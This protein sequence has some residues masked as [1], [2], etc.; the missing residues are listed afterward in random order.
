MWA[1]PGT[2]PCHACARDGLSPWKSEPANVRPPDASIAIVGVGNRAAGDDAAGLLVIDAL[3]GR[4]MHPATV[5]IEAGLAGP[6]LV[7]QMEG[8]AKIVLVDAVDMG[9]EPGAVKCFTPQEV[10]STKPRDRMS[11]HG[12]DLLEVIGLA[13]RLDVCPDDVVIVGIQPASGAYGGEV[14]AGVREA[15]G[16]A[17]S[18]ALAAAR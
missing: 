17:A 5:L 18:A 3:R 10:R 4:D 1:P 8:Y 7:S 9:L 2:R 16:R 15:I 11:L 12:C 13:Q 14:S 6:G